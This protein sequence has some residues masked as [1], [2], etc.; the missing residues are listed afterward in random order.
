ME[1]LVLQIPNEINDTVLTE[2]YFVVVDE[3]RRPPMARSQLC[4][5]IVGDTC[6][7]PVGFLLDERFHRCEI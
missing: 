3:E 4:L 2:E 6:F 1:T 7:K 5:A